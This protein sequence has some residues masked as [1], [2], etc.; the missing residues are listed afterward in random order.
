M[1]IIKKKTPQQAYFGFVIFFKKIEKIKKQ[2]EIEIFN[3]TI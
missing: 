3:I 2:M 1:L